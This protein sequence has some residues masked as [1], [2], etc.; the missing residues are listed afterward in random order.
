MKILLILSLFVV[1]VAMAKVMVGIVNIQKIISTVKEGQSADTKLKKI[2][3]EMKKKLEAEQKEIMELQKNLEKQSLV[4]SEDA[5]R[6]KMTDLRGKMEAFQQKMVEAD[7][8]IKKQQDELKK[9]IFTKL[10]DII[11]DVSKKAKV[12]MTFEVS[13]SPLVFAD[14]K[15]ELTDDIIK[16]YDK[17]YSK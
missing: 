1:N 13:S 17:K 10:K 2:Y 9:P 14:T 6:T 4:M 8:D 16:E 12:D 3:D 7:K 5:K 11:E 15:V